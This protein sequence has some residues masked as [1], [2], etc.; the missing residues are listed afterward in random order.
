MPQSHGWTLEMVHALP[1]DGNRYELIDGE[2]FVTPAPTGE[3]QNAA[4]M[5]WD[6]L[7]PFARSHELQVLFAPFAVRIRGPGEVQPDLVAFRR[8]RGERIPD[9]VDIADL[10]LAVEILSPG[11]TRA[12]RQVKRR[13]YQSCG[14]AEY[15]IVDLSS[16][17]IERW[18]P[19]HLEAEVLS[20]TLTWD[21][22]PGDARLQVDVAAYFQSVFD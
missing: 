12:D 2:L 18:S 17:A 8:P 15:W 14:V 20:T 16:R 21:P 22:P 5:L 4:A 19:A 6:L 1:D 9:L 3:H 11:T 7:H 13:L 10:V